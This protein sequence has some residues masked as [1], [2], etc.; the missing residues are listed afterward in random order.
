MMLVSCTVR[1]LHGDRN[2]HHD[3]LW[4]RRGR[5]AKPGQLFLLS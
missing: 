4:H 1:R 5:P 2:A 3:D